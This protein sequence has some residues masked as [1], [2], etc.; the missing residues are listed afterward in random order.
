METYKVNST[1]N[2]ANQVVHVG[3]CGK[4]GQFNTLLP[5]KLGE[6]LEKGS[7]FQVFT[8]EHK[9]H[10]AYRFKNQLV[11]AKNIS[12]YADAKNLL[13]SVPGLRKFSTD[14]LVFMY[15]VL[16][17]M[18]NNFLRPSFSMPK[19]ILRLKEENQR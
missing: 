8:D 10:L 12:T 1:F 2:M 16:M 6:M 13:A 17:A 4:R 14:R 18:Q 19:N 11:F 7:K 9:Q 5:A 3:L 15:S